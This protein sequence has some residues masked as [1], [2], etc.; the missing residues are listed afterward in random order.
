MEQ[1]LVDASFDGSWYS[2]KTVAVTEMEL[3]SSPFPIST[4]HHSPASYGFIE[5]L[6][7]GLIIYSLFH[8]YSSAYLTLL[9][10]EGGPVVPICQTRKPKVAG[11][12]VC[13]CH[14]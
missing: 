1:M 12:V 2:R 5:V 11:E 8:L 14:S 3:P 6:R 10:L 4:F 13:P 9:S 7:S